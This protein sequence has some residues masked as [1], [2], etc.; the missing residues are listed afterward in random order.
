M[1]ASQPA[2]SRGRRRLAF[3]ESTPA[4]AINAGTGDIVVVNA[5]GTNPV[6]LTTSG[7]DTHPVWAPDGHH[8]ALARVGNG[9]PPDIFVIRD[10]GSGLTQL[11]HGGGWSPTWSA[12]GTQLAYRNGVSDGGHIF[13]VDADGSHA[14]QLTKG[15]EEGNP[16][17]S[18]DGTRIAFDSTQ[19]ASIYTIRVN[20]TNVT[21][22]TTCTRPACEEDVAPVW[23][24]DGSQIVFERSLGGRRQIYFVNASGGEAHPLV[25]DTEDDCCTAWG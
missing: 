8:L 6:R 1:V 13:I 2:W 23:S 19:D 5:D 21:R 20:G 12:D 25:T 10:D 24:P 4:G 7:T 14:R 18:P 16:A 22:I 17:W 15:L 3:V 11:T 9:S